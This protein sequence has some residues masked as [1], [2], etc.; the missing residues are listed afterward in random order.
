MANPAWKKGVSGNPNGRPRKGQTFTDILEG[1]LGEEV[2]K[3]NGKTISGKEAVARKLLELAVSGDI[4]A[5]QYIGDRLDGR[6][7]ALNPPDGDKS[8]A[9]MDRLADVLEG[10]K[11]E[12]Q[13]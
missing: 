7:F 9:V 12:L 3:H 8:D 11:H 1:V 10:V 6:P 2:V 13:R 4:K 5:I